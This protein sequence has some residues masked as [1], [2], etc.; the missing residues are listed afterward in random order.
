MST[1]L[2]HIHEVHETGDPD[3]VNDFIKDGGWQILGVFQ[4]ATECDCRPAAWALY[5]L[6]RG[7]ASRELPD[8]ARV[9]EMGR[10]DAD[11][12]LKNGDVLLKVVTHQDSEGEFARFIIGRPR[13]AE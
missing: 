6:G 13:Q 3:E 12:A 11:K 8:I 5:V 9:A 7:D 2:S 4:R 1:T 10:E